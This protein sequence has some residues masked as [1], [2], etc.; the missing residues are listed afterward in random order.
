MTVY[1]YEEYC[2]MPVSVTVEEMALLHRQIM[3]EIGNNREAFELYDE[4]NRAATRYMYFRS[5]W[6]LWSR[7]ERMEKDSSRTSCHDSVIV[8][9][10]QLSRY[11]KLQGKPAVWRD[12]IGY[13]ENGVEYRRRIGDFACY[14]VFINSLLA[15]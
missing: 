3:D 13:E 10:N 9:F 1:T 6:L 7:D 15:R 2:S 11:L 8:K 14:L 4:L 12:S 5:N